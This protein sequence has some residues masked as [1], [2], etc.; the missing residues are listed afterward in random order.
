MYCRMHAQDE[1]PTDDLM[2]RL[3]SLDENMNRIKEE[4]RRHARLPRLAAVALY[5]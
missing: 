4:V 5:C 1:S 3:K 2:A